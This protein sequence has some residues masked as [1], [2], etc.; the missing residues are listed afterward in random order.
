MHFSESRETMSS[1]ICAG[2]K[3]D[4]AFCFMIYTE[5]RISLSVKILRRPF[6]IA[7]LQC[8]AILNNANTLE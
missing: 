3:D 6:A 1:G 8:W 4:C 5:T 7:L 2:L